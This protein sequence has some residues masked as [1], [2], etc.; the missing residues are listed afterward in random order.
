MEAA[1]L[2]LFMIS[3]CTVTVL[4]EHPTSPLRA[5]LPDS[6]TRRFWIGAAM[7]VTAV[8]IIASPW[9]Q[10]SGAHLN[11]AVTL[12]YLRLGKIAPRDA[13]A[14]IASQCT[15]GVLGVALSAVALSDWL[16]DPAVNFAVTQPGPAGAAVAFGAELAIAFLLMLTVLTVSNAPSLSRYTHW[17]AGALVAIYITFEAPF[18]GM[19]M[20]P[21]RSLGSAVVSGHFMSF[22]IYLTAPTL[23]MLLAA[24]LYR[25]IAGSRA[26]LCAKLHHHNSQRCIFFC[27]YREE[28][29]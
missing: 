5:A 12:A 13:L 19:S 29:L 20:N 2:A 16:R 17:C 24:E 8:S 23:G 15:G 18:S 22:W 3:A 1:E 28:A 7:G 25:A 4:F 10:R 9:G 6:V 27:R 21:A 14:Y 11:P 26:V